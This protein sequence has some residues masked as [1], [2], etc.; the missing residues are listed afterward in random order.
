MK[1]YSILFLLLVLV[2][3]SMFFGCKKGQDDPF[4][5][6]RS[7]KARIAG[8]YNITSK[9]LSYKTV[10]EDG[11]QFQTDFVITGATQKETVKVLGQ[12]SVLGGD[13]VIINGY[14]KPINAKGTVNQNVITF[15]KKG[16]FNSV[17][18]YTIVAV[19]LNE[20]GGFTTTITYTYREETRGSWDFLSGVDNFKKKERISMILEDSRITE[21]RI[22]RI[23]YV[24]DPSLNPPDETWRH[25]IGVKYANGESS[26]ILH[27]RELRSKKMVFEQEIND[28]QTENSNFVFSRA[29]TMIETLEEIKK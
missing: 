15:D 1:R 17:Y 22:T 25:D 18:E 28:Y 8:D 13:S 16:P 12:A 27:I 29:G 5:S 4:F 10:Y 21:T 2:T 23:N 26:Q 20:E 24:D 9:A 14:G 6:F 11:R 3:G 7:R 19:I